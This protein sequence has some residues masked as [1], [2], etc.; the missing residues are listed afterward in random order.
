MAYFALQLPLSPL[1]E[2]H[3]VVFLSH[4]GTFM[5]FSLEG[6][7]GIFNSTFSSGNHLFYN[8]KGV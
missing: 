6:E 2:Q 3:S 4:F 8:A 1:S 5:L 7:G